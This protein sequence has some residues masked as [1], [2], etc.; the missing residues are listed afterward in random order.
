MTF[1]IPQI[2]LEPWHS[3]HW[4]VGFACPLFEPEQV[5]ELL[6]T[7]STC[8]KWCR[9]ISKARSEE[10]RPFRPPWWERHWHLKTR[11]ATQEVWLLEAIHDLRKPK[12]ARGET[13][14]RSPETTTKDRAAHPPPALSP[15]QLQPLTIYIHMGSHGR[16]ARLDP[17]QKSDHRH[18]ER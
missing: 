7:S 18:D 1:P 9:L 10:V 13:T 14:C 11:A 4:E 2:F 12:P 17:F 3:S 6:V 15:S 16:T 8:W 5:C